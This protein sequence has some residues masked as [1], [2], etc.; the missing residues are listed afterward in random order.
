MPHYRL[1]LLDSVNR[2]IQE[3]TEVECPDDGAAFSAASEA[4]SPSVVEVWSGTRFVGR[5]SAVRH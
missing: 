4:G 5:V 3:G 1:Y 2:I